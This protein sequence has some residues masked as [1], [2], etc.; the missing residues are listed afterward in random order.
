MIES[1]DNYSWCNFQ[2]WKPLSV[3]NLYRTIQ[4]WKRWN[5]SRQRRPGNRI[6][7]L[8]NGS[9]PVASLMNLIT[10]TS[11]KKPVTVTS[12]EGFVKMTSPR[13]ECNTSCVR[14]VGRVSL[15]PEWMSEGVALGDTQKG[16]QNKGNVSLAEA[17]VVELKVEVGLVKLVHSYITILSSTGITFTVR[18]EHH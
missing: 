15:S 3:P 7:K 18:R 4:I 2:Q 9:V 12:L 10:F 16:N 14:I 5:K 8:S 1:T 17:L 11:L 6:E 13:I